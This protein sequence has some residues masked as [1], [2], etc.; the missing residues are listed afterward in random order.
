MILYVRDVCGRSTGIARMPLRCDRS[1]RGLG[2]AARDR[3]R[4]EQRNGAI[5]Y[6]ASGYQE[7]LPGMTPARNLNGISFAVANM[8]GFVARA[9][10]N[11]ENPDCASLRQALLDGS[12]AVPAY[13]PAASPGYSLAK[14][15]TRE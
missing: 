13:I 9:W 15:S 1:G 5:C 11:L 7:P 12:D 2:P 8:T 3:Y 4:V 6:V 10:V 14:E